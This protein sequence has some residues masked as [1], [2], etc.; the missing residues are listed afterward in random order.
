MAEKSQSIQLR[1]VRAAP[2]RTSLEEIIRTMIADGEAGHKEGKCIAF[3][4]VRSVAGS[5]GKEVDKLKLSEGGRNWSA[6]EVA[7]R[8]EART[9]TDAQDLPG[10]QTYVLK[11]FYSVHTGEPGA[12]HCFAVNGRLQGFDDQG[13]LLTEPATPAGQQM[14]NMRQ[15][16]IIVQR[17]FGIVTT[18]FEEQRLERQELRAELREVKI[19]GREMFSLLQKAAM[20]AVELSHKKRMEELEY[21]RASQERLLGMKM[22]PALANTFTGREVFPQATQDTA[23]MEGLITALASADDMQVKFLLGMLP[24]ELGGPVADRVQKALKGRQA[25]QEATA[26]TARIDRAS[27]SVDAEL[28]AGAE[29]EIDAAAAASRNGGGGGSAPPVVTVVG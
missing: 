13:N 17:T 9:R 18:I 16:E 7:E 25:A 3:A 10:V 6:A 4:V 24:P 15:A 2:P 29:A 12:E 5:A 26:R 14:Q 1:S 21:Q 19:E 11:A 27:A 23:L 22:L 28:G 8:F 20:D